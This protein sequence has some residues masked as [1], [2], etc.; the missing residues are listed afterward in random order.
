MVNRMRHTKSHQNNRRS[1]HAL[2]ASSLLACPKCKVLKLPQFVCLN[3]GTYKGRQTVDVLKK[4]DKKER[5]RK[6]HELTEQEAQK[7]MDAAALS[8]TH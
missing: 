5:K 3:C 1:H 2:R 4:L 6:E 8:H 7:P